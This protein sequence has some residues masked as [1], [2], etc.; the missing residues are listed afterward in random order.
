MSR[1]ISLFRGR[2]LEEMSGGG[3]PLIL[4]LSSDLIGW[5]NISSARVEINAG[6]QKLHL[7]S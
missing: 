1:D 3:A 5:F 4:C 7:H 2:R 6:I